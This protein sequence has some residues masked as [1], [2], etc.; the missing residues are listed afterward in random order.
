MTLLNN[1]YG[2]TAVATAN[3][4]ATVSGLIKEFGPEKV[5]NTINQTSPLIGSGALE[6]TPQKGQELVVTVKPGG[7]PSVASVGDFGRRP[8]GQTNPP[9]KAR[10]VPAMVTGQVRIGTQA[11][12]AV[13]E[14]DTI[15]EMVDVELEDL[16]SG[17]A[18]H[19]GRSLYRNSETPQAVAT[20]SGTA[21]NST[22]TINFLDVSMFRPG[23][24]YDFIDTS[25]SL[26]YVIRCTAVTPAAVGG[27]SANIAGSVSF[28]NDVVNPATGNVVA[29]GATA[30]AVDDVFR[31]RGSTLGF[32]GSSALI[33]GQVMNSF[34]DMSSTSGVFGGLDPATTL[35]WAGSTSALGGPWNQDTPLGFMARLQNVSGETFTHCLMNPVIGAAH[36]VFSGAQGN[37]YGIP[38]GVTAGRPSGLKADYDKYGSFEQ[39]G[40]GLKFAGRPVIEDPNCP[41][42]IVVLHNK[43]TAKLGV[44]REMAPEQKTES[45]GIL[46]NSEDGMFTQSNFT[47]SMQLY[48]TKRNAVGVITGITGA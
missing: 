25:A 13:L 43:R 31:L 42:D 46:W 34:V 45:G 12:Q 27:N 26:A 48:C 23:V 5:V 21:A 8:T 2:T 40:T 17:V 24:A 1:G 3:N 32:G 33:A 16:A 37:V 47:G 7:I 18:R 15:V 11:L 20:W 28:I 30:V 6:R 39:M 10:F 41:A 22:V 9:A 14:A 36:A 35:G 29:L 38:L 4:F 19:L 44:W